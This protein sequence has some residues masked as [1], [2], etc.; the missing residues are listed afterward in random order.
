MA[1]FISP[2]FVHIFRKNITLVPS[3]IDSLRG[4]PP[5]CL[6][7]A[8]IKSSGTVC[9]GELTLKGEKVCVAS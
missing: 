1:P 9:P 3:D 5:P 8:G 7:S 6:S 4:N 2:S